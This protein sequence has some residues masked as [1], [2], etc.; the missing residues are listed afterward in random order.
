MIEFLVPFRKASVELQ[1]TDRPS[2]HLIWL[3]HDKLEKHFIENATDSELIRT[4]K[5][6]ARTY[7]TENLIDDVLITTCHKIAIF[8]HPTGKSL[9]QMT[10]QDKEDIHF[11]VII[12]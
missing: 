3:H 7:Y 10:F 1:T 2:L 11:E 9:N 4:T 6:N 12:E 5:E 8:L